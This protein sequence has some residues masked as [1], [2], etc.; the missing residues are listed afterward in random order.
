MDNIDSLIRD[1]DILGVQEEIDFDVACS[2]NKQYEIER[3]ACLKWNDSSDGLKI[4]STR[5]MIEKKYTQSEDLLP[6][7]D[8]DI[9]FPGSCISIM[10]KGSNLWYSFNTPKENREPQAFELKLTI[11]ETREEIK[12]N[13]SENVF[14]EAVDYHETVTEAIMEIAEYK[15]GG[16]LRN[17]GG[18][19]GEGLGKLLR[20]YDK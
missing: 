4:D 19:K 9:N 13:V 1:L 5:G 10:L 15:I 6:D 18:R 20:R 11:E 17:R 2:S 8:Y 7:L 14:L 3:V 16:W 12:F